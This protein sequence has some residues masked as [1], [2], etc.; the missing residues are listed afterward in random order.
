MVE[1]I[2]GSMGGGK[3]GGGRAPIEAS[4]T[5]Q[6]SQTARVLLAI[7]EGEINS[8][9]DIYLN[10]TPISNFE[11]ATY[12]VRTGLASQTAIKGFHEIESVASGFSTVQLL[13]NVQFIR[14]FDYDVQAARL[15]FSVASLRQV[16]ENGDMVGY[17]VSADIY[18]RDTP[19]TSFIFR[20]A[21]TKKGKASSVY[22]WDVR[23]NRPAT[24]V[25][26]QQWAVRIMRTTIDDPDSKKQSALTLAGVTELRLPSTPLTYNNTALVAVTL[27]DAEQ[28]GNRVPDILVKS[29]GEKVYLPNTYN[30]VTRAYSGTWTGVFKAAKEYCDN[31]V[32]VLLHVITQRLQV[33]VTEIDLG[34]FYLA[35]QRADTLVSNGAAGTEPRYRVGNQF[36]R[37]ESNSNFFSYLLTLCDANFTTNEFGQ[38]AL[39]MDMPGQA[40]KKLV[41]NSNVVN[42]VF[43]YS[44]SD[45]EHRYS[46]VNV[47]YN[48]PDLL[49]DTQTVTHTD[50]ALVTRYGLQTTDVVLAGCYS[51]AQAIRKARWVCY[52][53]AYATDMVGFSV[54]ADGINYYVGDLIHILDRDNT[55]LDAQGRILSS[56]SALGVTTVVLDRPVTITAGMTLSYITAAGTATATVSISNAPGTY[57]S[58]NLPGTLT[59]ASE[60]PFIIASS[61]QKPRTAKI[62]K[63]TQKDG[64]TYDIQAAIHNEGKYAYIDGAITKTPKPSDFINTASFSITAPHT[65]TVSQ[66]FSSTGTV[67]RA[68]LAVSWS[69]TKGAQKFA[70]R[71]TAMYRRD[72]QQWTTLSNLGVTSFDITDPVPG[73][74]EIA[75]FATNPISNVRSAAV[76]H[77]YN[78]RTAAATSSLDP[79]TTVRVFGTAGLVF[80]TPDL[81]L[82]IVHNVANDNKTDKLLDYL[83]EVWTSDGVTK[84]ATYVVPHDT[85]NNG[86]FRFTFSQNVDVFGAPT[87]TFQ[88]KV[89]C[90]DTVGDLS[91]AKVVTLSNPVPAVV[92]FNVV[93][94]VGFAKIDITRPAVADLA[95]FIVYRSLTSGFTPSASDIVYKG[96]SDS[97]TI[98]ALEATTYYYKVAA[99][100]SFGET[101]LNVSGQQASTTLTNDAVKWRIISGL[102]FKQ[103]NPAAN[104]V[105]WTAGTIAKVINGTAT[106]FSILASN[107]TYV[108]ST[109]YLY[110]P[111]SGTAILS[112]TSLATA[113]VQGGW[114]IAAY[115]GGNDFK[116]G[117]GDAF[118]DGSTILAGTVGANQLITGSAV[119]TGTAQIADTI[120]TNAKI[121][122][123]TISGAKIANATITNGNITN[124]TI[125]GAKIATATIATGNIVNAAITNA[126]IGVAAVDSLQIQG[127]AVTVPSFVR[128]NR[129]LRFSIAANPGGLKAKPVLGAWNNVCS[130]R[131]PSAGVPINYMIEY[132][133]KAIVESPTGQIALGGFDIRIISSYPV[134]TTVIYEAP[135]FSPYGFQVTVT[136]DSFATNQVVSSPAVAVTYTLQVR[137]RGHATTANFLRLLDSYLQVLGVKR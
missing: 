46:Q 18:T 74:Y 123:A 104:Q 39:A 82:E 35:A 42:G 37:R 72:D 118:V 43:S 60:S 67:K 28:F 126:K 38:I 56:S 122:N 108:A 130:I 135:S 11:G 66:V 4:D 23:I 84:K 12:E 51:E 106:T 107:A 114:L 117:N 85:A 81:N 45:R 99:F 133:F 102:Q 125:T 111:G 87:R 5:L 6:S 50:A 33:P 15:T 109:V 94:G 68:H 21:T 128:N 10:R 80:N 129:P 88:V 22:A 112:T 13:F 57:S 32:W 134:A 8:V 9:Q 121:A 89:Y 97:L 76:T 55:G 120:I 40:I 62:I 27:T 119:I 26:G 90:R 47:T 96:N 75:I 52:N 61:T 92:S 49:G 54:G 31:P 53:S 77:I 36:L 113:T 58:L 30:P 25:P 110:Y 20:K 100:D 7:G 95:G 78:Y 17:N 79:V 69:W 91:T 101:G 98:N 64:I 103:N 41:T 71:F 48:D 14:S 59:I 29:K 16:L 1:D 70:P 86:K 65:V 34:S 136:A 115:N 131:V 44:S 132:G 116:G 105:S 3:G 137:T 19:A 63:V 127:Q 73:V 2:T 93:S 24:A 124:A 83:V